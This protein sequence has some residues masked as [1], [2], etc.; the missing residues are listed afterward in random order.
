DPR[1]LRTRAGGTPGSAGRRAR[2][3]SLGETGWVR[4]E[5][6]V[7]RDVPS[8]TEDGHAAC[9]DREPPRPVMLGVDPDRGPRRDDDVLI[10]DGVADD[11]A[12]ADDG[13]VADHRALHLRASLDPDT[14]GQHGPF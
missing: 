13:P 10:E 6:S 14:R 2:R 1:R 8:F 12:F 9:A 3:T 7:G 11:G 4:A 5:R